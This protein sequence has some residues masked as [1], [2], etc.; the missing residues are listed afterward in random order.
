MP[1]IYKKE[2]IMTQAKKN[3]IKEVQY[4]SKDYYSGLDFISENYPN[5]LHLRSCYEGISFMNLA[6]CIMFDKNQVIPNLNK[7]LKRP[8]RF[9]AVTAS[10]KVTGVMITASLPEFHRYIDYE[11]YFIIAAKKSSIYNRFLNCLSL[12]SKAEIVAFE[13]KQVKSV[14]SRFCIKKIH[15]WS[16]F[17]YQGKESDQ[18]FKDIRLMNDSDF[19]KVS[20]LS[21]KIPNELS[22][23][24]SLRFQLEGL[25]YKN[26]I[27]SLKNEKQ[28]FLGI[29][30]YSTGVYQINYLFGPSA[31]N[32]S[33][34][35]AI[36]AI[37][38]IVKD[39]GFELIWRLRDKDALEKKALVKQSGLIR[40]LNENHLH[41]D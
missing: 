38:K 5:N 15:K 37:G 20:C 18:D 1:I 25:P 34:S 19:K 11:N 17:S 22:P 29:S 40:L 21:E 13:T 36:K 39:S 7:Y 4:R 24:R 3:D 6:Q 35:D 28:I 14:K 30:A 8:Q 26:F 12:G 27:L 9:V 41:L 16:V 2:T 33:L 32:N 10:G 31:N 23:F